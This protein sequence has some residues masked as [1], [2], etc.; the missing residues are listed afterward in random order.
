[1]SQLTHSEDPW[2]LAR[3][4]LSPTE[5]SRETITL[6]SMHAFYAALDA[7]ADAEP[8]EELNWDS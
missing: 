6:D 5:W 3:E 2:R 8:V 7:A 1:M 4:G